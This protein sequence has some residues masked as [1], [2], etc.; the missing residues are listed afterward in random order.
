MNTE[1]IQDQS[2]TKPKKRVLLIVLLIVGLIAAWFITNHATRNATY[3][4]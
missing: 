3:H 1:V 4:Q 2:I